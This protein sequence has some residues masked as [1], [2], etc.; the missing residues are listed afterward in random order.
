MSEQPPPDQDIL[1][2]AREDPELVDV[3]LVL[4]LLDREEGQARN[5]AL[6]TLG[7]VASHDPDMV[8]EHTDQFIESL[9]DGFPVAES[10]AARVLAQIAPEY[11][12]KVEPAV[13]ELVDMLTQIPPLTG[14]RAGRAL[15]PV[16]DHAPEAFVSEADELVDVVNDPPEP[17]LPTA[18]ELEEMPD[19]QRQ[20]FE[21]RLDSR[22]EE[23]RDDVAR[24]FGIREIAAHS[25][26]EVS[27]LAP[28][29]VVDR[30]EDLRP[31]IDTE[32]PVVQAA[33]LDVIANVADYDPEAVEPLLDDVIERAE[34]DLPSVRAHAIKALGFA[35]APEAVD[36]LREI[37]DEDDPRIDEDLRELAAETA[38]YIESNA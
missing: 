6:M 24:C 13:P 18:E 29:A 10:S 7:Y 36:S 3:D 31:A 35:A 12:E 32:P 5:V 4:Q 19:D 15:A 16:L 21:D 34:E 28:E 11:P 37:A 9:E 14:Y 25:L 22:Q 20:K 2:T 8:V 17:S 33:T 38:D 1:E 23:A 26:V 27:D 30:V